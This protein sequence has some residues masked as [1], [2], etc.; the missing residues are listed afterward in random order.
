MTR[1]ILYT[2]RHLPLSRNV[3]GAGGFGRVIVLAAEEGTI[4]NPDGFSSQFDDELLNHMFNGFTRDGAVEL[5]GS[6]LALNEDV[7]AFDQTVRRPSRAAALTFSFFGP[8]VRP[9]DIHIVSSGS[10]RN[11]E[12]V[13]P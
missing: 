1:P 6:E 7:S 13:G 4:Q 12:M 9:A 3:F 10:D 5:T 2:V 8:T 11:L